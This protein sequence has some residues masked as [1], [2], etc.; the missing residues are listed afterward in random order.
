MATIEQVTYITIEHLKFIQN[1]GNRHITN[2]SYQVYADA[3]SKG[4]YFNGALLEARIE[5]KLVG[6]SFWATQGLHASITVVHQDYRRQGIGS[7]LLREKARKVGMYC[8]HS[9]V[10]ITN[11]PSLSLAMKVYRR[12]ERHNDI[13]LCFFD[14]VV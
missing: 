10:A 7:E 14:A 3:N 8:L 4:E 11:T 1:N 5:G 9:I 6:I 12:V 2:S 13:Q